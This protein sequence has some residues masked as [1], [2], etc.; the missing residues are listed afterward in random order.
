[1]GDEW[2][3]ETDRKA[4]ERKIKKA[5]QAKLTLSTSNIEVNS[6]GATNDDGISTD[7]EEIDRKLHVLIK[8]LESKL[9]NPEK[10]AKEKQNVRKVLD[11]I[12]AK[13]N[14]LHNKTKRMQKEWDILEPPERSDDESGGSESDQS[15]DP[16]IVTK[17]QRKVSS[18]EYSDEEA[19]IEAK[20]KRDEE[21]KKKKENAERIRIQRELE[22]REKMAA[23]EAKRRIDMD[24]QKERLA[25]EKASKEEK[26]KTR[27]SL[28]K[29]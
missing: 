24:K 8:R 26:E 7:E 20:K 16:V 15:N 21:M 17:R 11:N 27:K 10:N 14:A 12:N 22:I 3:H 29:V 2:Q 19:A 25:K 5:K 6:N 13:V 4:R 9:D 1:M 18:D 23:E 28:P